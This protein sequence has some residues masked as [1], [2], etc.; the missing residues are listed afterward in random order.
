MKSIKEMIINSHI[1]ESKHDTDIVKCLKNILEF[2]NVGNKR[3]TSYNICVQQLK[4]ML[5]YNYDQKY[6]NVISDYPKNESN[7]HIIIIEDTTSEEY[8]VLLTNPNDKGGKVQCIE[9][10]LNESQNGFTESNYS[11]HIGYSP[12]GSS[13]SQIL[14]TKY[15]TTQ[16]RINHDITYYAYNLNEDIKVDTIV[17]IH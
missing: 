13:L 11:L 14:N 7:T 9:L 15:L 3:K 1:Y 2:G 16:N 4:E 17:P 5:D 10:Y 8:A 6:K 12:Q